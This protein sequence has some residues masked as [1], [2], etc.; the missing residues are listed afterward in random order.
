MT[1]YCKLIQNNKKTLLVH[2]NTILCQNQELI[3]E[4]KI[5]Y[6]RFVNVIML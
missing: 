3:Q 2:Q 1:Y 6:V 4:T 5:Y